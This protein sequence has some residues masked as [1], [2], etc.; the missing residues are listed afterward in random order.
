MSTMNIR[1]NN[2]T[3]LITVTVAVAL[4]DIHT[5]LV[6]LVTAHVG[7]THEEDDIVVVTRGWSHEVQL[8][9]GLLLQCQAFDGQQRV[10]FGITNH[11]PPA[12]LTFLQPND[13]WSLKSQA[14]SL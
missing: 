11:H 14:F 10:V 5:K 2:T 4:L 7:V 3:N 12:F 6:L 9:L 8:D 1:S 13:A